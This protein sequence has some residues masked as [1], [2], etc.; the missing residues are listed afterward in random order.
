MSLLRFAIFGLLLSRA[1]RWAQHVVAWMALGVVIAI[2]WT[3]AATVRSEDRGQR[4]EEPRY[5]PSY[6]QE[7]LLDVPRHVWPRAPAP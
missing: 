4:Y 7:R 5:W 1:P 3:F 6:E 2:A